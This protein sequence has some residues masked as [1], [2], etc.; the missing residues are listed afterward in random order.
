MLRSTAAARG[1]ASEVDEIILKLCNETP[2]VRP[3]CLTSMAC[4]AGR[5]V[6]MPFRDERVQRQTVHQPGPSI[7]W[8]AAMAQGITQKSIQECEPDLQLEEIMAS[9]NSLVR[10][11]RL[12]MLHDTAGVLVVRAV[13]AAEATK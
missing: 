12:E 7:T 1:R 4:C 13:S 5:L 3:V 9:M 8:S 2:N 10:Q 6:N 11:H